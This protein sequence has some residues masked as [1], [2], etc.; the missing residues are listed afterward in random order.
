[1][2]SV[3][4]SGGSATE[5]IISGLTRDTIYTIEVAAVNSAG[6]GNYSMPMTT[7]TK[8]ERN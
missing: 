2:Q 7:E 6:I 1:M 5:S 4:V 8:S 3:N